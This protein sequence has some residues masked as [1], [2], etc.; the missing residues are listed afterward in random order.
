MGLVSGDI[1]I[2]KPDIKEKKVGGGDKQASL[3]IQAR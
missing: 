2:N 3:D 1:M